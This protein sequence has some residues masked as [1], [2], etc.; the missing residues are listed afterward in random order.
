MQATGGGDNNG[1]NRNINKDDGVSGVGIVLSCTV[2]Y[3]RHVEK[4]MYFL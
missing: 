1:D 2:S 4:I 3:D